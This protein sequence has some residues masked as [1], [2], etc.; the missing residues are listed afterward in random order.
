[1]AVAQHII[2]LCAIGQH[3]LKPDRSAVRKTPPRISELG[4]DDHAG[5]CL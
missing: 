4:V 1:M 2:G 5:E 3:D